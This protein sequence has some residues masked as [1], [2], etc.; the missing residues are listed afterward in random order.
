MFIVIW[1]YVVSDEYRA[2][3]EKA[4]GSTGDWVKLFKRSDDYIDTELL[5]EQENPHRYV[6]IDRWK[7]S[8][9][10]ESFEQLWGNEYKEIDETCKCLTEQEIYLGPF[11]II[12]M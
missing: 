7:T 8:H 11:A 6:T 9:A 5:Q 1:K 12:E 10:C 4:Y 2:D 3:F